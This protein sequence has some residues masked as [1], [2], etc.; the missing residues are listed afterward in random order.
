ML[1]DTVPVPLPVALTARL[2]W[3]SVNVATAVLAAFILVMVQVAAVVVP[4]VESQ[5]PDQA[6]VEPVEAVAV[7]ITAVP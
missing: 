7:S 4:P 2:Y 6:T 1:E 5:L 3:V